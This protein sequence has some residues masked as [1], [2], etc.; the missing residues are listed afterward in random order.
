MDGYDAA[1]KEQ[2]EPAGINLQD[3]VEYETEL[4]R[5]DEKAP[6]KRDKK[7]TMTLL[8]YF[9]NHMVDMNVD[10][11]GRSTPE[12]YLREMLS[13]KDELQ[14]FQMLMMRYEC[15]MSVVRTKVE[16]LNR[17]LALVQNRNPFESIKSRLKTPRSIFE[18]LDRRG[19]DF[20]VGNIERYLQDIAGVR[21]ICSFIDDIIRLR[22][23]LIKQEDVRLLEEK[24]YIKYPKDNG[25]RSLHLIL[26]VPVY[27]T[28]GKY[29]MKVEVQLRTIA[30]DFWATIEHKMKYKRNIPNEKSITEE[31]QYSAEMINQLDRRMMQLRDKIDGPT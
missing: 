10:K 25:Y 21:V 31:L 1:L 9:E 4:P 11:Y 18:K 5:A 22:D 28:T 26:E 3:I 27:L 29:M 2:T 20:T 24:D 30:M 13:L 16:V 15:A 14:N 17:E 12:G 23:C 19:I 7:E 6:K 8:R